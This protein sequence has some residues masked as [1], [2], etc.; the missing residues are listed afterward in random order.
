MLK[1]VCG[2]ASGPLSNFTTGGVATNASTVAI[3]DACQGFDGQGARARAPRKIAA[4]MTAAHT[5]TVC[6][7]PRARPTSHAAT[8]TT[9]T[10]SQRGMA[11]GNSVKTPIEAPTTKRTARTGARLEGLR[12]EVGL[13][14]AAG[15]Y[16][17]PRRTGIWNHRTM[18]E[19]PRAGARK[20]SF[21]PTIQDRP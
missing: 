14:M 15:E 1:K 11:T 3:S 13:F 4:R 19:A 9:A 6:G 8:G 12:S 16:S 20:S 5:R 17:R 21:N 2:R 10:A 18:S 7:R